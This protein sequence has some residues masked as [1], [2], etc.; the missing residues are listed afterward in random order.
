[1]PAG[2]GAM[3]LPGAMGGEDRTI[4]LADDGTTSTEVEADVPYLVLVLEA[5]RPTAPPLRISLVGVESL[6]IRRGPARAIRGAGASAVEI[7]VPDGWM[8]GGGHAHLRAV[9]EGF[10]LRD[11]GSK[12][13]TAVG[14]A[15]VSAARLFDGDLIETGGSFFLYRRTAATP[16]QLRRLDDAPGER[17][18]P[19]ALSTLC[20][21]HERQLEALAA[22]APAGVPVA[23]A[24]ETGTGKELAARA[25]HELS[26]RR[27]RFQAVNCGAL[28]APLVE[29]ELFGSRRGAF[30]GALDR[31][32]HVREASG[33]T[34]FL[35]EIG[36]LSESAQVALLRVLQE[37]EVT[38]VGD[39][40]PIAVD[41]RVVAASQRPLARLVDGG[42]FRADLYA[43]LAGAEIELL[44]LRR[45]REDLGLLVSILLPRLAGPRADDVALRRSAARALLTYAFPHNVR[46]LEQALAGALTLARDRPIAAAD[47]PRPIRDAAEAERALPEA[48]RALKRALVEALAASGGNISATAR[49]LGKA[50]TQIRR[51]CARF[52]LDPGRFRR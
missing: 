12:N 26:G 27:G 9:G 45:R 16:A 28:P 24:G 50:R 29:S 34:L 11:A 41:L 17:E 48:D 33:G 5:G 42:R 4:S 32:G 31:R 21:E 46:E 30:S 40:R 43:R 36:E 15:R 39:T 20:L 19:P 14:G 8:S 35:D 52:D 13:G 1:M 38:A 44:P 47:L 6:T 23:I 18:R 3:I 2:D 51:W 49:S 22:S 7:E 10:E 25:L 37:R